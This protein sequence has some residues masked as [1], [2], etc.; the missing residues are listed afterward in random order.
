[1]NCKELINQLEIK[2]VKML[3]VKQ[4]EINLLIDRIIVLENKLNIP[5]RINRKNCNLCL[6]TGKL[7]PAFID[8][9][10]MTCHICLG[11]GYLQSDE[12]KR[13]EEALNKS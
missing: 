7:V 12:S 2:T 3:N 9:D 11:K 10:F 6:G 1:M 8:T 13:I 5:N 4:L